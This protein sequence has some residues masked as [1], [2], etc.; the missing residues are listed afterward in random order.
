MFS[1]VMQ[2]IETRAFYHRCV[3]QHKFCNEQ[4]DDIQCQFVDVSLKL[5]F[6]DI[7]SGDKVICK[8]ADKLAYTWSV[9]LSLKCA[10]TYQKRCSSME[11]PT[12]HQYV[13]PADP[14]PTY[15]AR[16]D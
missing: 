9:T 13:R 2:D 16:A 11:T 4:I 12:L 15:H 6:R 10:L 3:R 1:S 14:W 7:C 5:I 8:V